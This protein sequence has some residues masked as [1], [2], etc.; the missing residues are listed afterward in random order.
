VIGVEHLDFDPVTSVE[1]L[2]DPL[3]KL[4]INARRRI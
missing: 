3:E 4:A 1:W 2:L